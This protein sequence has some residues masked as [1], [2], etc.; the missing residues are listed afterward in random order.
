M[1]ERDPVVLVVGAGPTGLVLALVLARMGVAV[2][3]VDRKPGPSRE[4]RAL[5]V[6]ARTL[7][8]YRALGLSDRVV[9]AGLP[10]EAAEVR[11]EGRLRAALPLGRMGQGISPFPYLLIYPQDVHE[12]ML[13]AA[14]AEAGV[15]VDWR[16][17]LVDFAPD[18]EGVTAT[19]ERD[20][21]PE[22]IRT[23]WLVGAD[24]GRSTV[25]EGLGTSFEGGT[26]EG[27]FYVA[28]VRAEHLGHTVVLGFGTNRF[29][30]LFP[31]PGGRARLIG[32]VPPGAEADGRINYEDVAPDA[33]RLTGLEAQDVAWFSNYHVRHRVA[34]HFRLG[35]CFLA[36]DAGHVHS[37]LGGQGMN[38]GIGDALNLAWKL[39]AVVRGEASATILDSYGAERLP[40]ARRL[41]ATTDAA[42]LR[43]A[44]N[45]WVGRST[46]RVSCPPSWRWYPDWVR[47]GHLCFAPSVRRRSPIARAP[48]PRDAGGGSRP[49]IGCLGSRVRTTTRC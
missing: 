36:G 11:V 30:V 35:R 47:W 24:G 38:T 31:L 39:E 9:A 48:S 46:R 5:G 28:D 18:A 22:G 42:F 12:P 34:A 49:G 44:N 43:V 25:R 3:I 17:S 29:A 26:A 14:L 15:A 27:L 37:P 32:M 40:F 21:Q 33:R 19:L 2:R 1:R 7:E 41:V 8:L 6:Q 13:I 4:S 16:T 10:M 20:G 45:S 23:D